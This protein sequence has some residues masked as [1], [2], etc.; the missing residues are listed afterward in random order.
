MAAKNLY[1]ASGGIWL[2]FFQRDFL[3]TAAF[4]AAHEHRYE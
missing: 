4:R 2:S 3:D 1:F